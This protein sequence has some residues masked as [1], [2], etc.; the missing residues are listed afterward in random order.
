MATFKFLFKW[1]NCKLCVAIRGGRDTDGDGFPSIDLRVGPTWGTSW[2][3][4]AAVGQRNEKEQRNTW[5]GSEWLSVG[6]EQRRMN[7]G[8]E[9]RWERSDGVWG[10][11]MWRVMPRSDLIT[12]F[13]LTGWEQREVRATHGALCQ[14]W[15]GNQQTDRLVHPIRHFSP[16]LPSTNPSLVSP[17]LLI[18]LTC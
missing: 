16:S 11:G 17:A 3:E 12:V 8:V 9:G 13:W 2:W 7:G 1:H 10:A 6:E 14:I 15:T 5:R 4:C 18:C